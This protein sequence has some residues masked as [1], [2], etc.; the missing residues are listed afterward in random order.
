[1]SQTEGEDAD[2]LH[3][4]NLIGIVS[5]RY[6]YTT[7][8][9][10]YRS[11]ETIHVMPQEVSDR[12]LAFP[13]MNDGSAFAPELGVSIVE[14]Y[15][16]QESDYYVDFLGVRPGEVLEFF[17]LDGD[18]AAEVGEVT[19]VIKNDSEDAV[20]LK[21]GRRYDFAGVGP[22]APVAVIRVRTSLNV[23]A[24]TELGVADE[25]EDAASATVR[26][27]NLMDLLRSVLPSA[28]VEVIPTAERTYPDS[29]QRE[30]MFQELMADLKGKQKSNPRRIRLL[31]R[32]VDLA[33]AL[34]NRVTLRSAGGGRILGPAPHVIS[35]LGEAVA[36]NKEGLP[37]AIPVVTAA[38]VLNFDAVQTV[39]DTKHHTAFNPQHVAPRTLDETELTSVANADMYSS[40]AQAGM[41]AFESYFLDVTGRDLITLVGPP[42][43]AGWQHDQDVIRTAGLGTPVQGLS[44]GLPVFG[45]KKP[46][47][48]Q[49]YLLN[50]VTDRT[51]RVL[52]GDKSV[53]PKTGIDVTV[54]YSD[55]ST[56]NSY[57]ML[58]PKAAIALRPSKNPGDL[59]TALLYSI[60][61]QDDNLP[62]IARTLNDLYGSES[63]SP[64]HAWTLAADAAGE[65]SVASWLDSVLR[66]TVH[67][68]DSLG[69]RTPRLLTLLD[70]MGLDVHDLSPPVAETI[71]KWVG[72]SHHLWR[73]LLVKN[74]KE[75]QSR[76][77]NEQ[78]RTFQSVTGGD[79]PLWPALAV[80]ESLKDL[81]EDI[82]RRNPTIA[83]APTLMT[84]SLLQ[85]AQGDATPLVWATIG[86]LDGRETTVD[87]VNAANSLAASRAYTLRRKALRDFGLLSL[88]AAPEINPC[89]HANRLEAVRNVRD[90]LERGRLLRSFVEEYQGGREGDWMTCALCR[91]PCVCYHEL[92][93]LEALAQPT[94]LDA[95]QKQIM[96]RFGGERYEGKI[97]CRNCGQPLRDIEYDD[98][99]EFDDD[100][101]PIMSRSVLTEEQMEDNTGTATKKAMDAVMPEEAVTFTSQTKRELYE[102]LRPLLDR[103]GLRMDPT[104]IQLMISYADAYVSSR[105]LDP[106]KY[107]QIRQIK[108]KDPKTKNF[109]TYEA[110]V[111][112]NRVAAIGSLLAIFLQSANPVVQLMNPFPYCSFSRE[113]W[114]LAA[115]AKAKPEESGPLKYVSCVVAYMQP[116][117][118]DGVLMR[119]WSNMTWSGEDKPD[120]RKREALKQLLAAAVYI[121]GGDPKSGQQL[122]FTPELVT[123]L[124]KARS[125]QE[126]IRSREMVTLQD[127]LPVGFRPEPMPAKMTRP[128]LETDPLAAALSSSNTETMVDDIVASLRQ[129]AIAIA[130]ELHGAAKEG[131]G[132]A[133]VENIS[134]TICCATPI[135]DVIGGALLGAPEPVKL[136]G[137]REVV[138]GNLP[139]QVNTGTHL[140]PL[141]DTPI[142]EEVP[143]IIDDSVLFKLF[144]KYCYTGPQVGAPH[145]FDVGNICRQCGLALGKPLDTVD[146]S[147]DGAG[148]LAAQQGPLVVQTT[149]AAFDA[150]SDAVRRRKVLL[151]ASLGVRESWRVGLEALAAVTVAG[152][153]APVGK[154]LEAV[155]AEMTGREEEAMVDVERGI[156]WGPIAQIKDAVEEVVGTQIGPLTGPKGREAVAALAMLETITEDPFIEGPRTLQ[157]YWCA[158]PMATG[159]RFAVETV[160]GANWSGVSENHNKM[161][162]ALLNRNANWAA[163]AVTD[164]MLPI[165][166]RI[167]TALG[168][169]LRTWV[170]VVRSSNRT[171][172]PWTAAEA[173]M[174]LRTFVL[175]AWADSVVGSSWMYADATSNTTAGQTMA[176]IA[177][178]TRELMAA[179]VKTQ[180]V[181]FSGDQIKRVLQERLEAERTSI[182]EEFESIKDDD[183]RGAVLFMK[184]FRIGR[185]GRGENIRKLDAD[186]FDFEIEQ[187]HKMGIVDPAVEPTNA[188]TPS[189]GP[190]DFGLGDGLGPAE[191][192]YAMEQGA[193]G[194]DY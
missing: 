172:G 100:G 119:P 36:A 19:E 45:D 173:Q 191:D 168:P 184:Q 12:A 174:L 48:T 8:R 46:P 159:S 103:A 18:R 37:A 85:E 139:T 101:N 118:P 145:E 146:F 177:A 66:Y 78:E 93:E 104:V 147:T 130:G 186:Q 98:R 31:E 43:A 1:M 142:V 38:K 9:V 94:R 16:T 24:A 25:V 110:A 179:H 185:W 190:Q 167:A 62:T 137:A 30:D 15:E 84:A 96:V 114:P 102:V 127:Q 60:T 107:E 73:D 109:P 166:R 169:I 120:P 126:V 154:A 23:A 59:P 149:Q 106:V 158:K 175:H 129:Q 111:D 105:T 58:P 5:E 44:R 21:D 67:P 86:K 28:T 99:V 141:F 40:G 20:I 27:Q 128:V 178:W 113:G 41:R 54:A 162:D 33:L 14:I 125:D 152:P 171:V 82:K 72:H 161:I 135:R 116:V 64:Q 117:R 90:D 180:F 34:K 63:G 69:P 26:N 163:T 75:I 151:P 132:G 6:G 42:T 29:A 121:L 138:R 192:G 76:L 57:I 89:P 115:P 80:E 108:L 181:R 143:Q 157:E 74:R 156:L 144:L 68:V 170:R 140:W 65:Y 51:I 193:A 136:L 160:K 39:D 17:T 77:D 95:I 134:D 133:K 194:D 22:E 32:E 88:S 183:E 3:I 11:L 2:I 131:L 10:V 153:L 79:S 97:V 50:D 13:M 92:M 91:K 124:E 55:P 182:V 189:G 150:L 53:N 112:R 176:R 155:L 61:L 52:T 4:G 122:P 83:E 70:S 56:I 49:A 123:A 187:R 71:N 188:L 87:P 148:I 47:V 164:D 165:L 7:G 81:M 35:T